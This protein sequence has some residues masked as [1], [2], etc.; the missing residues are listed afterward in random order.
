LAPD[1][2]KPIKGCK[3]Q[4][5][6]PIMTSPKQNPKPKMNKKFFSQN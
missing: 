4:K 1:A 3:M 5:H 2:S 6:A